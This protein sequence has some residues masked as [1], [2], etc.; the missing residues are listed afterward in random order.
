MCIWLI[1]SL[2]HLPSTA[3]LGQSIEILR[4]DAFKTVSG[5]TLKE[6]SAFCYSLKSVFP[7]VHLLISQHK[8][9]LTADYVMH[10]WEWESGK[11][12]VQPF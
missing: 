8:E 11:S 1:D 7:A 10:R 4:P 5:V 9:L 6:T 12:S 2:E 3:E